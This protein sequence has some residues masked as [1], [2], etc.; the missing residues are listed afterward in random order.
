VTGPERTDEGQVDEYDRLVFLL[1]YL[2]EHQANPSPVVS[3]TAFVC[4]RS[5]SVGLEMRCVRR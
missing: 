1:G 2:E 4:L 3:Q 5:V